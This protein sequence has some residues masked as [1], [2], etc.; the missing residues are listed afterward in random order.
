MDI[1]P[2]INN[3]WG[4][5]V[6]LV[7]VAYGGPAVAAAAGAAGPVSFTGT[8]FDSAG[9]L[10]DIALPLVVTHGEIPRVLCAV[11]VGATTCLIKWYT[12]D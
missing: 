1:Q 8:N 11:V 2:P 7:A 10:V 4:I 9:T 5:V 12:G 6:I 3:S